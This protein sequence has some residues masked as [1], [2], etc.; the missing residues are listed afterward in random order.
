M[1]SYGIYLRFSQQASG[2]E[3]IIIIRGIF[4]ISPSLCPSFV[5]KEVFSLDVL[6]VQELVLCGTVTAR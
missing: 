1:I 6:W 2:F 4:G 3:I 5:F